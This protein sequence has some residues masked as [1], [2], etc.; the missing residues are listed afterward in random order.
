VR[1]RIAPLRITYHELSD[2]P[3]S[4]LEKTLGALGVDKTVARGVHPKV[5]KV[6][7]QTSRERAQ[8][9]SQ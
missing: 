4:M 6:A 9:Y 8:R 7:D 3:V 2:A 1:E 5:R